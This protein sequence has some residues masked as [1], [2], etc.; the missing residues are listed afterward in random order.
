LAN[1][2]SSTG[3]IW[4]ERSSEGQDLTVD[5]RESVYNVNPLVGGILRTSRAAASRPR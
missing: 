1:A 2:A 5:L 3:A 4:R